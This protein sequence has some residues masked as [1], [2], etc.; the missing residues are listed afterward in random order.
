MSKV[1]E[2]EKLL[3]QG[4]HVAG[5]AEVTQADV[6][7]GRSHGVLGA[8][9]IDETF[10]EVFDLLLVGNFDSLL[11]LLVED[12]EVREQSL[13]VGWLAR[14]QVVQEVECSFTR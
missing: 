11:Y 6:A 12:E 9:R 2:H 4:V 13:V 10:K 14:A 7:R 8:I 3:D 1:R 5:A